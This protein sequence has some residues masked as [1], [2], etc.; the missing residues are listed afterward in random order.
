MNSR[1][2]KCESALSSAETKTGLLTAI[3]YCRLFEVTEEG[4]PIPAENNNGN[5]IEKPIQSFGLWTEISGKNYQPTN[6]TVTIRA[7]DEAKALFN[8]STIIRLGEQLLHQLLNVDTYDPMNQEVYDI[9]LNDEGTVETV[10]RITDKVGNKVF[11]TYLTSPINPLKSVAISYTPENKPSKSK[12]T[13]NVNVIK[14]H[15]FKFGTPFVKDELITRVGEEL[16]KIR[17]T[18]TGMGENSDAHDA[19][20]LVKRTLVWEDFKATDEESGLILHYR[21]RE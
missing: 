16:D 6:I 4:C 19:I 2:L 18:A 12:A 13:V 17:D 9:D 21:G 11:H 3:F 15:T 20:G 7:T 5:T 10:K 8:G 1:Y 14:S